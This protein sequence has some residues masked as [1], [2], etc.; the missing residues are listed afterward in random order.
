MLTWVQV[1]IVLPAPLF[2]LFLV[3]CFPTVELAG[4]VFNGGVIRQW[5]VNHVALPVLPESAGQALVAWFDHQ[6]SF[7]QEV[8]LHLV[9]SIDLTLLLLPVTYGL[10]K[11]IIFISSWA[12]TTDHDLKSTAARH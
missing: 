11:A 5:F 7:A 1:W 4:R 9:I 2:P 12:S 8:I 6:A 3:G 10:G